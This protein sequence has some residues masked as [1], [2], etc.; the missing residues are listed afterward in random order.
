MLYRSITKTIVAL[1]LPM[2][3]G[4]TSASAQQSGDQPPFGSEDAV[5]Y[6]DQLWQALAEASLVGDDPIRTM[7]YE[8]TEPHGAILEYLEQDLTI[9]GHE[10]LAIVKKNYRGEQLSRDQV[11]SNPGEHLESITVMYRRE[12]GYDPDHQNWFW[13]KHNPDG[14]LQTN[15][16]GMP[17]AGRVAKG[18]EMGCIACHSAAPGGDYVYSYDL[19]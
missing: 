11:L 17:L 13:T 14:S 9:D 18:M 10:G 6:A 19:Q 4:V 1:G 15:E 5:A 2:A 12:Q 8:G 3:L 7:P 16:Q